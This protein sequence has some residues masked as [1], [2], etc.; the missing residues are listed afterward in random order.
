[1]APVKRTAGKATAG[2]RGPKKARTD[3]SHD[4]KCNVIAATV[5]GAPGYPTEI[6]QLVSQTV[7][8][9]LKDVKEERHTLATG[10][11]HMID[12]VLRAVA[13]RASEREQA[14]EATFAASDAQRASRDAAVE[15][16]VATLASHS[17]ALSALKEACSEASKAT[18]AARKALSEAEGEQLDGDTRLAQAESKKARLEGVVSG[19]WDMLKNTTHSKL[20]KAFT[21]DCTDFEFPGNLVEA[22][23]ESLSKH[24]KERGT[25]DALVVNELDAAFSS[26]ISALSEVLRA[27]AS[28]KEAR[29]AKVAAAKGNHTSMV[30]HENQ[31]SM[32]LATARDDLTGAEQQ[33]KG[34]VQ[35]VKELGPEIKRVAADLSAAKKEHAECQVVLASFIDLVERTAPP[36]EAPDEKEEVVAAGEEAADVGAGQ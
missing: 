3:P 26:R 17:E 15:A 33:R 35:A 28:A 32:S 31:C 12:E 29:D 34:R 5:K 8:V 30:E 23:S 19:S 22:A 6:T 9:A 20:V 4:K 7:H 16:A 21:K 11:V 2:Q 25:F 14:L 1:M 18:S 13:A 24:P 36:P 10:Y 27:G